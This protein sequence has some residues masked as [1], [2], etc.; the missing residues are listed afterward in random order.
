MKRIRIENMFFAGALLLSGLLY[1]CGDGNEHHYENKVFISGK[2]F[3]SELRVDLEDKISTMTGT[4]SVGMGQLENKDIHVD[5]A[6]APSLLATYRKAYYDPDAQLLPEGHYDL[7]EAMTVI[8]EGTV[9]SDD[10]TFTFTGLDE[11]DLKSSNFVLPVSISTK[12]GL[13][14]LSSAKTIYFVIKEASLINVVADINNNWCWPAGG[15]LV[16]DPDKLKTEPS[17][18][19]HDWKDASP[20]NGL[21]TFTIETLV[22][23]NNYKDRGIEASA[24]QTILGIEDVFLL[25]VGD[26]MIPENQL[27]IA[28]GVPNPNGETALRD[29]V[30]NS[31]MRILLGRWYH[32]AV[33]FNSGDVKVYINGRNVGAL[34]YSAES[35]DFGVYRSDEKDNPR[36]LWIGSSYNLAGEEH[37]RYMDGKISEIRFWNK[38]LTYD[39]INAPNHFYRV[40]P[41]SEGLIGYW[42]LNDGKGATTAKDYSP[43]GNDLEFAKPPVWVDVELPAKE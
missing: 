16:T 11:L 2:N 15:E 18:E 43:Y 25:R 13:P 31:N 21:E 23:L 19:L 29:N 32:I 27:Q 34:S 14:V 6:P 28:V 26:A 40:S 36:C 39:E 10:I 1:G 3:T 4:V 9:A 33:T 5:F 8:S 37:S 7:G 35:V 17:Y 24:I 41:D 22:M 42:K 30:S 38:V 12:D 20:F